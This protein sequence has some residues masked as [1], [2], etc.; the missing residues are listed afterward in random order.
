MAEMLSTE[1][2]THIVALLAR[3]DTYKDIT[4][5]MND[6]FNRPVDKMTIV[7]VK[8]RNAGNLSLIKE[9]QLQK[10]LNDAQAIKDKAN[11]LIST[12]LNSATKA[13]EAI[14][15]AKD[16][17]SKGNINVD[18][19]TGIIK[20]NITPT[21]PELFSVSKEMHNQAQADDKPLERKDLTA[22]AEALKSGDEIALN[23]ILIKKA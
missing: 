22:L 7:N 12:K 1:Q 21:L 14:D 9:K 4:A 2:E 20:A 6:K 13:Q 8:K 23:Q 15:K 16:E 3:G 11:T 10:A 17:F 5:Q 19:L 18:E